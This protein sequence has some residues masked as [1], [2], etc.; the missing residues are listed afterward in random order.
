MLKAININEIDSSPFQ[1]RKQ[2]DRGT[3]KELAASIERE[4]QIEPIVVR[5][6]GGP[7]Y[8]LIAGGRRFE[9][10]RDFTKKKTILARIIEAD[11]LL[12]RRISAAENIQ[13]ED[14]SAVEM[15]AAI[16]EIVD[17]ELIEDTEYASMG[18]KPVDRVKAMLGKLHSVSISKKRGSVVSKGAV[19]LFNKFVKQ[20]EKIFKN[21]PKSL[22]WQSF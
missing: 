4:G 5:R 7:N 13:R 3:L 2:F 18:K 9:A 20:A 14:L 16:V 15:I 8:Q 1:I 11:D 17:A 22:E 19:S 10:V 12:A 6:N 21:L